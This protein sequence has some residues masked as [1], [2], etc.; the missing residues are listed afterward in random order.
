VTIYHKG[1][2]IRNNK[3]NYKTI[4]GYTD[5]TEKDLAMT[6]NSDIDI[7]WI[8]PKEDTKKTIW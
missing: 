5:F 7:L 6:N 3:Y 1:K 8:R 2:F 4:G